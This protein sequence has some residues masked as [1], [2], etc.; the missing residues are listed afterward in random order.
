[1]RRSSGTK[2]MPACATSQ[3][4]QPAM[5]RPFHSMRPRCGAVRPMMLRMVVVLPTPLRPRRHTH[6]P[7]AT[8]SETPKS[9]WERPYDV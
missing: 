1:M 8:W 7:C 6:S 2:P 5:S 3:G 4:A 9:T